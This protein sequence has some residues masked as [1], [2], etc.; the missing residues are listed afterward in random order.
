MR[1]KEMTTTRSKSALYNGLSNR[2][3]GNTNKLDGYQGITTEKYHTGHTFPTTTYYGREKEINSRKGKGDYHP[4]ISA[5]LLRPQNKKHL[6][7]HKS[8]VK[9]KISSGGTSSGKCFEG[10]SFTQKLSHDVYLELHGSSILL[11]DH[12]YTQIIA[13]LYQIDGSITYEFF[14]SFYD[15][16]SIEAF[17]YYDRKINKFLR[18]TPSRSWKN[19]SATKNEVKLNRMRKAAS[20][21]PVGKK[22]GRKRDHARKHLIASVKIC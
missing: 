4:D 10:E 20:N 12:G 21:L 13:T 9:T 7:P 16:L 15:T 3:P 22:R 11:C 14:D 2:I 18:F 19:L 1:K 6:P 8:K 17:E 5:V